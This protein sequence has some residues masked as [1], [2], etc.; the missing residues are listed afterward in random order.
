[1]ETAGDEAE[2]DDPFVANGID[3]GANKHNGYDEVSEGQPVGAVGEEWVVSVGG[4]DSFVH[5]V[6]P[7]KQ[8]VG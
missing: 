3:P 7:A 5:L 6:Q 2:V 8:A 1:V 4:R